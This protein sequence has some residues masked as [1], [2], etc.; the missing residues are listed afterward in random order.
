[1][2]EQAITYGI[3]ILGLQNVCL[4]ICF[5]D[6]MDDYGE[7]LCDDEELQININSKLRVKAQIITIFHEL[8]HALQ[9]KE[10]RPLCENEAYHKENLLYNDFLL[11][12]TVK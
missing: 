2:I 8:V 12:L 11:T 5:D 9:W 3:G 1:M 6:E 4:D 7:I 10:R